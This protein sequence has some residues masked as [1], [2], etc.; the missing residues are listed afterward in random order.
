MATTVNKTIKSAGGDYTTVTAWEAANQGDLVAADEIRQAECF[1]LAETSTVT[2]DGSTTDATRYLRVYASAGLE[3]QMPFSS[4]VYRL[5]VNGNALV[6]ADDYCRVE[7]IQVDTSNSSTVRAA[8]RVNNKGCFVLGCLVRNT[9]ASNANHGVHCLPPANEKTIVANCVAIGN[10]ATGGHGFNADGGGANAAAYFYN[11]TAIGWA[12]GVMRTGRDCH[13]KNCL[14][15][16]NSGSDFSGTFTSISYCA[17]EDATASGTGSRTSQTFTFVNAAGGDYHLSSSDAGAKDFGTDLSADATYAFST[18]FDGATRSGTWDIGAD[19]VVSTNTD[20]SGGASPGTFTLT[21]ADV[22][23]LLGRVLSGGA[24]PGSYA[25]SGA[26]ATTLL[27]RVLNAEPG[28]YAISGADLGTFYGRVMSADPGSYDV[29]GADA[30]T[31]KGSQ[32]NAEPGSYEITGAPTSELQTRILIAESGSYTI[33]GSDV[34]SLVG[35]I[36]NAEPGAYVVVGA[37]VTNLR[38]YIS[39]ALPGAY[40][41]TGMDADTRGGVPYV[42]QRFVSRDASAPQYVAADR[43]GTLYRVVDASGAYFVARDMA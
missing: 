36:M 28:A 35:R 10:G 2:I 43:S 32:A 37:D 17:S 8:I 1:A 25:I 31:A 20:L 15:H 33:V 42:T 3:A 21:G 5:Q 6:F 41:I 12:N 29:S 39:I 26:D 14:S 22:T 18:D 4:S 40:V 24:L 38:T 9:H 34:S 16:G 23:T 19:E 27:G 13:A 7:R 30:S 11:C